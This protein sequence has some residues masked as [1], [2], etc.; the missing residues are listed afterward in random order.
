M[1]VQVLAKVDTERDIGVLVSSNLKMSEQ[2]Y[3][4]ANTA[5]AVLGQILRAFSYRDKT[6]LPRLFVR[7][8]RPHLDFA[9]QAWQPWHSQ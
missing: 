1:N 7:Y 2:C 8:V 3:K 6:V 9:I 5:T 4:T